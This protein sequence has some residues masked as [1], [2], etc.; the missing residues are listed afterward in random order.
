MLHPLLFVQNQYFIRC[1]FLFNSNAKQWCEWR[2]YKFD[3]KFSIH[4]KFRK[5]Q[6]PK[7]SNIYI[8]SWKAIEPM[9]NLNSHLRT[10][11]PKKK[12]NKKI[13]STTKTKLNKNANRMC[14]CVGSWSLSWNHSAFPS[15]WAPWHQ[16][17]GI[18]STSQ[19]GSSNNRGLPWNTSTSQRSWHSARQAT[20]KYN[21]WE[22]IQT[23]NGQ[24]QN[25]YRQ[26]NKKCKNKPKYQ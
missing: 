16:S 4:T 24:K 7:K 5:N 17:G 14:Y 12:Q 11:K 25:I 26:T 1:S 6:K 8:G 20:A 21:R 22:Y 2:L 3:S 19:R 13:H 23:D 15:R 18:T 9:S 10:N